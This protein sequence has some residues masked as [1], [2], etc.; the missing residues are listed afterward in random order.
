MSV[1]AAFIH[2]TC[3]LKT[4]DAH[5][6]HPVICKYLPFVERGIDFVDDV[7]V[8]DVVTAEAL[9]IDHGLSLF[10]V[11]FA[12]GY[13]TSQATTPSEIVYCFVLCA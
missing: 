6:F 11:S 2:L 9:A 3:A 12:E 8:G 7:V 13:T 1:S 4:A 10:T 5:G